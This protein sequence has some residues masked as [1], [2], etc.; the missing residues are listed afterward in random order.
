MRRHERLLYV[1]VGTAA[2]PILAA[3]LEPGAARPFFHLAVAAFGLVAVLGNLTAIRLAL[4]IHR[5]LREERRPS[6]H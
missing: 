2:S 5:R 3:W 6:S 1:G 4:R